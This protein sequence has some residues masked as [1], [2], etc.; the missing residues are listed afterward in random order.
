MVYDKPLSDI[1]KEIKQK[2]G[3]NGRV[4]S[5]SKVSE[6]IYNFLKNNYQR[7][8]LN[9]FRDKSIIKI[10]TDELAKQI[11][12][13]RIAFLHGCIGLALQQLDQ[14]GL[15]KILKK[16]CK[17]GYRSTRYIIKILR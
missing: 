9:V 4:V 1:K 2:F 6:A 16:K 7:Y 10:N 14:C 5:I 17:K 11:F 8:A 3:Y 15:I 12:G 13:Y